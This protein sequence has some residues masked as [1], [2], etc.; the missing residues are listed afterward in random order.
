MRTGWHR[1]GGLAPMA[2]ATWKSS[3]MCFRG[4]LAHQDSLGNV[5]TIS[6]GEGPAHECWHG[7]AAQRVQSVGQCRQP[8]PC[9][10]GL[11]PRCWASRRVMNKRT[12][13]DVDKQGR[14]LLVASRD[15]AQDSVRIH[16]N[17]RVYAGLFDGPQTASLTVA[18]GRKVYV[19]LV[20]GQLR[21]NGLS[22]K[23]GDA[24]LLAEEAAVTLS[25]GLDA[26]VLVFD[27]S[28]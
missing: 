8:F 24:A 27:L 6:P 14:L 10:S 26:E 20:R 19:H 9:R 11:S 13:S 5:K 16:A 15:G 4:T 12:F 3:V 7:G 21:V 2:I 22:L 1:A 28:D 23:T 17:A 25:D 18:A